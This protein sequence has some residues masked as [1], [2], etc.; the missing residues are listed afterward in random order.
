MR[1]LLIRHGQT[2]DNVRG[3]LGTV[4]PG[5]GLTDL[6]M[7]QAAAIPRALADERIDAIY[8]S[9]MVRTQLTAQPLADAR[10][11]PLNVVDGLHEISAG[12]LE[13]RTDRESIGLYRG[14]IFAWYTDLTARIP[15][16]EDGREFVQR[17][18]GAISAIAEEWTND[19]DASVV[20]VSHG[21][22]I[23]AWALFASSN[24]DPDFSRDHPLENTAVIH[25]EGSPDSGWVVSAWAGEPLGG[26]ALEDKNALDPTSEAV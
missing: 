8:V 26:S 16:G 19:P 24:V 10:A 23:R 5:P 7:T 25:L 4:V 3:A 2:V 1:L 18:D 15:G 14:S 22:A 17:F 13:Q 9:T 21:A 6:G 20:I 11:L 12:E